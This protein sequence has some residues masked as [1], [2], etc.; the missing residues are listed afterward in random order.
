MKVGV[1]VSGRGSNLEAL[2]KA[3]QEGSL[4]AEIVIVLSDNPQAQ[5]LEKA[6]KYGV[7]AQY[8]APCGTRDDYDQALVERLKAHGVELVVLAGFMR[9]VGGKFLKAFPERVI[10]IH[11]SLLPAFPGLKA[12][13]QAVKYGVKYSGCT[14]HFVD[15]GLDSGP[16]IA[17]AVVPVAPED[18]G[19]SLAQRILAEEHRLLPRVVRLLAQGKVRLEGRKVVIHDK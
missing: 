2:L 12:Q 10:N 5:A 19:E 8:V 14:V 16:I 1:L 6:K 17:Q 9:L 4:G 7:Q 11:P 3:Q 15:E 18:D 13:E